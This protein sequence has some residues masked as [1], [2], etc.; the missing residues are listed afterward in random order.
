MLMVPSPTVL[1][2]LSRWNIRQRAARLHNLK[3]ARTT[4]RV[5]EQAASLR[6]QKLTRGRSARRVKPDAS[7]SL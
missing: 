2:V 1:H 7:T 6:I 4:S 5:F 3:Y